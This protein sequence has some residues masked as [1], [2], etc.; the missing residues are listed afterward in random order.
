MPELPVTLTLGAS[1]DYA[2]T[3]P[4]LPSGALTTPVYDQYSTTSDFPE[5]RGCVHRSGPK[6]VHPYTAS[7]IQFRR[8]KRSPYAI[9]R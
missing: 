8:A 4:Y 7:S 3:S 2:I 6:R 9:D 1:S 5:S